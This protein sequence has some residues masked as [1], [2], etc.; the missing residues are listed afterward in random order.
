[1]NKK[2]NFKDSIGTFTLNQADQINYMYFPLV[3]KSGMKSSITPKVHGDAKIDQ[4]S[5]ALLPVSQEDLHSSLL[6]RNVWFSVDEVAWALNGSG[7]SQQLKKDDVT[8]EGG[9]LYHKLTRK[10]SNFEV[11]LTS[12]V[13]YLGDNVEAHHIVFENTSNEEQIVKVTT[14]VPIYGR[15]AE[16]I[17][18]HRHVT[19]LLNRAYVVD[20]GIINHPTMSFDERGHKKNDRCY[21]VF[22]N[23]E[24]TNIQSYYPILED[25]VGDGGSLTNPHALM[26]NKVKAQQVGSRIDGFEVM[27]AIQF[28]EVTILPNQT[29][30]IYFNIV[31]EDSIVDLKETANKYLNSD[32]FEESLQQ[33]KNAW[34]EIL[35]SLQFEFGDDDYN[36]WLKW[37]T[38]QPILRRLYGNSFLPHHDY[39]KGGRG[40]RDLWQDALALLLLDPIDVRNMLVV[41]FAGV[42]IDGS[43]A[44]IIGDKDGLFLSDR[45]N[46]VR[47][48]MDHGVW[49]WI[50]IKS[51]I[52]RTGDMDILFENQPYFYDKHTHY[53]KNI[54]EKQPKAGTLKNSFGCDYTGTILEHLLIENLVPFFNVGSHNIMRLENADWNDGLDM[55]SEFGESVPFT[56]LYAKNLLEIANLLLDL[57][58]SGVS[59]ISLVEEISY[60]LDTLNT[61]VNYNSV[62]NKNE[63]LQK[64]FDAVYPEVNGSKVDYSCKDIA[65]DLKR[66]ADYIVKHIRK[67][68][69]LD[70]NVEGF[71]NGY[72]DNDG[73]RLES[74]LDQVKMTLTGQVFPIMSNV[75]TDEQVKKI[76]ASCDEYLFDETIGGYRLNTDFDEVKTNMGRMFGFA[77]GH[78]ENGAVFSHMAVMYA[79]ALY[80]RG[81]VEAGHKA[82]MS[83]FNHAKNTTVSKMYPGLPEYFD[84]RGKG[85]YSYLTGS[86]SWYL[87][88]LVDQVYGIKGHYGDLFLKPQLM[89]SEFKDNQ[90]KIQTIFLGSKK[91]IIYQNPLGLNFNEY[92]IEG[93]TIDGIEVPFEDYGEG[94]LI[95]KEAV[96]N[97]KVIIVALSTK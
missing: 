75:A 11:V 30:D 22:A 7:L 57:N 41:N 35:L 58:K 13:P 29:L 96:R 60:L 33:T 43:N 9:F 91:T 56:T 59:K 68:E 45:N 28:K 16:A 5:F 83:L 70:N 26:N 84:Q 92:R 37:V 21:G 14:A 97:S 87:L 64:Y 42:R 79:N 54:D 36:N 86:A 72:Y 10:Q 20:N 4:N 32:Q 62:L 77:Y 66:K 81:Y 61:K 44:T 8:V 25:F 52:D 15:S 46:I 78:K 85:M 23:S 2:Y 63:Q 82:L 3:G 95:A 51:Y 65:K 6:S 69:W 17:R 47:V 53:S 88:T 40:W 38:I 1:M 67:Q 93:I 89:Q 80:Q 49:P 31:I 50:T 34:Q 73:N 76:I 48:W 90:A 39:G 27:G 71:Y 55:A 74:I 18:D 24:Q 12:F 94:I 19:A